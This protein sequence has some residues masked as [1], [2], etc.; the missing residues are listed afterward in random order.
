VSPAILK[1]AEDAKKAE[2]TLD[3]LLAKNSKASK[4]LLKDPD[5]ATHASWHLWRTRSGV[6]IAS[7]ETED[8][9]RSV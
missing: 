2:E 6:Y 9:T 8:T 5:S 1:I 3:L 4:V 7:N